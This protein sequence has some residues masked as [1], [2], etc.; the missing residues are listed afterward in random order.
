MKKSIAVLLSIVMI[1]SM[2]V[3]AYAV[4]FTNAKNYKF[5]VAQSGQI[6]EGNQSSVYKIT[7]DQAGTINLSFGANCSQIRVRLYDADGKQLTSNSP[8][9][10]SVTQELHYQRSWCLNKGVYYF[11]IERYSSNN[12]S[13][14]FTITHDA[15]HESFSESGDVNNNSAKNANKISPNTQYTGV[16]TLTDLVDMYQF[17][18]T[19]SGVCNL[20]LSAK[21][22]LSS[23]V[24]LYDANGQKLWSQTLYA[25]NITGE[26]SYQEELF[27]NKGIYYISISTQNYHGE[28]SFKLSHTSAKESFAET[29]TENNN[30]LSLASEID[31]NTRYT[32]FIAL[33]DDVDFY[34]VNIATAGQFQ[35]V[36][37]ASIP[38]IRVVV[39]D[40]TGKQL[41]SDYTSWNSSTELLS[42]QK[43]IEL[44][45]GSYYFVVTKTSYNGIYSFYLT[46]GG[47]VID[48]VS[49][50]PA[51]GTAYASTQEITLDGAVIELQAYA[52][53]DEKG[54]E[55][56]YV[57]LRDI[58]T[59]IN[60]SA[61]QFN[62]GWDG[63][64][65]IITGTAYKPNGTEM[66]TPFAGDR[67]Y[68]IAFAE[69]KID[70]T[71]IDAQA[72]LLKDDQGGGYT[73]YKLRDIA[74]ALDFDVSWVPGTGIVID[75][76][77]PYTED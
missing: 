52:L 11:S 19:N 6:S 22:E 32:G 10:N 33:K 68:E 40:E 57:K 72:I 34:K 59:L 27:L 43:T 8:T 70:G 62:V 28:Y 65:N 13:Y 51:T 66:A 46:D 7:L 49:P 69:T 5:G 73:Y 26:I 60:G 48:A 41:Q 74:E 36:L 24:T 21:I 67:A 58:A 23:W 25:N 20:T 30:K 42:Y 12:G 4:G 63:A 47:T 56:N 29:Q 38:S 14:I 16:I 54:Y 17:E 39:Y 55:T 1:F 3:P 61:A 76:D 50:I 15:V 37:T 44:T 71:A 2:I 75:T 53:K 35:F 18:L 77:Q 9:W 64:V 31:L 45:H